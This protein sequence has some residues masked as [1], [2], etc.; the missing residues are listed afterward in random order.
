[1]G[2]NDNKTEK[3]KVLSKRP[4]KNERRGKGRNGSAPVRP[5]ADDGLPEEEGSEGDTVVFKRCP[6]CKRLYEEIDGHFCPHCHYDTRACSVLPE[7]SRPRFNARFFSIYLF[8]IFTLFLLVFL[9]YFIIAPDPDD[10]KDMFSAGWIFLLLGVSLLVLTAT[11]FFALKR[12]RITPEL[13]VG[14]L[15]SSTLALSIS[16]FFIGV[17]EPARFLMSID[18][19]VSWSKESAKLHTTFLFLGFVFLVL[20]AVLGFFLG[21]KKTDAEQH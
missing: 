3:R 14:V 15:I 4:L 1:M 10:K 16:S 8:T 19:E 7:Q 6:S 18:N 12:S 13:K 2:K 17:F 21:R 9:F 5:E 11:F 20:T